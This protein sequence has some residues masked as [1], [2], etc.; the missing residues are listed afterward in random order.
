MT[1]AQFEA[2][3]KLIRLRDGPAKSAARASLTLGISQVRAARAAG[4]SASS[5]NGTVQRIR[6]AMLLCEIAAGTKQP[7]PVADHK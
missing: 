3:A 4:C 6:R 1:G 2:I 5:C 7:S